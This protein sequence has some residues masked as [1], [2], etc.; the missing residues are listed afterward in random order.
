[1][2]PIISII[3]YDFRSEESAVRC[4][5]SIHRQ[6][7]EAFEIIVVR[8]VEENRLWGSVCA[9]FDDLAALVVEKPATEDLA[10]KLDDV[11]GEASGDYLLFLKGSSFMVEG[12][13]GELS[14]SMQ[15]NSV[16]MAE[17]GVR[18]Y[19]PKEQAFEDKKRWYGEYMGKEVDWKAFPG[20]INI[21]DVN[22]ILFGK[23]AFPGFS[24]VAEEVSL[25]LSA[26]I[27]IGK[28]VLNGGRVYVGKHNAVNI[29]RSCLVP[30]EAGR[31]CSEQSILLSHLQKFVSSLPDQSDLPLLPKAQTIKTLLSKLAN[32][33][34]PEEVREPVLANLVN[35]ARSL[36][37]EFLNG[38]GVK[39]RLPIMV[40]ATEDPYLAMAWVKDFE[41]LDQYVAERDAK[42]RQLESAPQ[43]FK[44]LCAA[45][46]RLGG[47][48]FPESIK[49]PLR[50]IFKIPD[51]S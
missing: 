6:F 31:F 32:P 10:K 33:N 34:I 16:D 14:K 8:G 21:D 37:Q 5:E 45:M 1:M 23:N 29:D 3:I 50:V 39:F 28:I 18:Y 22:G 48:V 9:C 51:P 41:E 46:I 27:A 30:W 42:L 4:F 7:S 43:S 36:S 19:D 20:L 40:L 12:A 13:M 38:V 26:S 25:E 17:Y 2:K 24:G 15:S 47:R 49:S 35:L 11:A 44:S